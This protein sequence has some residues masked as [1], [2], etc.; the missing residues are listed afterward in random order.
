MLKAHPY[1]SASM[2]L[3]IV[4]LFAVAVVVS[5]GWVIL[6]G[7]LAGAASRLLIK[8]MHTRPDE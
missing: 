1:R 8:A 7:Y 2:S 3:L 4:T 5:L 6:L